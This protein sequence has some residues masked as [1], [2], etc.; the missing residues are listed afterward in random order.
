[1]TDRD[2]ERLY[3]LIDELRAEVVGYRQD[4]RDLELQNAKRAGAEQAR[5]GI[6]KIIVGSA[7]VAACVAAVIGFLL[8]TL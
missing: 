5:G 4:V 1:M 3:T 2:I 7:S 6:G 8:Q